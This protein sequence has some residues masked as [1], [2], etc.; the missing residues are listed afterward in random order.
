[1]RAMDADKGEA[2]IGLPVLLAFVGAL[3]ERNTRGGTIVAGPLNL[4]GSIELLPNPV[5]MAELAVD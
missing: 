5:A 1:M 3:L 4:G 2:G